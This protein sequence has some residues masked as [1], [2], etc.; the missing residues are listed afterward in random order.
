MSRI[1]ISNGVRPKGLRRIQFDFVLDGIRLRPSLP[2]SP[3]PSNL[4]KARKLLDRIKAQIE[5]GTFCFADTFPNF[6]TL[7]K[8]P[9]GMASR[10]CGAVFDDFLE[11]EAARV[12]RGDLAPITLRSHRQIL[13]SVWRPRIGA[14]AFLGVRHSLLVKIADSQNWNKK[15][16]NNAISALRRAFCFGFLD[17][18]GQHNPTLD[19]H[20]ARMGKKDRPRVDPFSIQDAEVFIAAL[21]QDW[22]A[23]QANYDEF[24]FFTGLRPS[25]EIALVV[26]DY[27]RAHGVLSITKARVDG[28]DKD[29]TKTGDDRRIQLCPRA[30]A[31]LER[32]LQLRTRLVEQGL[33]E[34]D[35][36]F[37]TDEGAPIPDVRYP[38]SRW[39][40]TLRRLGIRYRRPYAARHTSVSWNLMLGRNPLLVAKEHGH[41][42]LTMLTVYAAW[43]E[44]A[45]EADLIALREAMG[46]ARRKS[47]RHLAVTATAPAGS[48][49]DT[50]RSERGSP[51]SDDPR[52]GSQKRTKAKLES[53]G[54]FGTEYGTPPDD[55]ANQVPDLLQEMWRSGRDSNPRPPA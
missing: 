10:N 2:W 53:G 8:L 54:S 29:C 37:F 32:H 13:N 9:R 47:P 22:G 3:T 27:D 6:R 46:Y 48:I 45:V 41:R 36:L 33:I 26:S 42:V 40:R 20:G 5:A 19:L 28:I 12:A 38:Y 23:P 21:R 16:Y 24:R 34:H 49:T 7:R 35:H 51:Q 44:G 18:P 39:E 55:G 14:L 50:V 4:E 17:Y 30:I 1:S 11:H 31:T 15:T 25:E 43:T 52:A